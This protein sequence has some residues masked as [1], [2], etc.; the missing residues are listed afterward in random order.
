MG[1]RFVAHGSDLFWNMEYQVYSKLANLIFTV[2]AISWNNGEITGIKFVNSFWHPP[3]G[4]ILLPFT[5]K[6]DIHGN[7]IYA[8]DKLRMQKIVYGKFNGFRYKTVAWNNNSHYNGWN[9]TENNKWEIVGNVHIK[10]MSQ[11]EGSTT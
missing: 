6:T 3:E 5:G 7:K 2:E 1:I 8:G 11:N 4:L 10:P 9:I